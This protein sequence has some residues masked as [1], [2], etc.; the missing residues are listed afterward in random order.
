MTRRRDIVLGAGALAAGAS[1]VGVLGSK[2]DASQSSA[3]NGHVGDVAAP[4]INRGIKQFRMATSWPKDF[5]GLG[6]MP[7]R[8]A[9]AVREMSD[10]MLDVKV[11]AAGELVGALE[12]FNATS[13]G[14]ADMY[15]AAEYYWQGVSS[16]FN[17]FTSVP[18]GMTA[19]ELMGWIDWG[20]GQ[21]LWHELSARSNI[22][23][24]QAGNSGH[25]TGG[26]FKFKLTG[27]EDLK[28]LR[29]R[30][31]GL[32][33]R[34]L[35]ELGGTSVLLPGGEIYQALQSGSIDATEWVGPWNDLALGFY[36]E[37]PNYYVPGF[38]EPG[39][40]LAVGINLDRW[41]QLTASEQAIIRHA[42]KSTNDQSL[43]E[44][45]VM[46]GRALETLRDRH[47]IEP[48]FMPD[49]ILRAVGRTADQI[50]G[51]IAQG[52]PLVRRIFDSYL[53]SRNQSTRWTEIGDG[54]FIRARTL[55]R[56]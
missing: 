4:N 55:S 53:Q 13:T 49:D 28:G 33:G 6:I 56:D 32:G 11:Y 15:H 52:D 30:I 34:V 23:A 7:V 54:A 31:P 47:G 43:G 45:T 46:N 22:I 16:G 10:G 29:M 19:V 12:C 26:W 5:P 40:A 44:Y 36:R 51:D 50:V 24:F 2:R 38:H 21:D 37:A 42:C 17:F 8:F 39:S 25:Q 14:A 41:G 1:V 20:G 9:D 18:M 48:Q 3:R 35:S 27:L